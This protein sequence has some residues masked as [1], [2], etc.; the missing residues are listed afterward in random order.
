MTRPIRQRARPSPSTTAAIAFVALAAAALFPAGA[1]AAR[2]RVEER[3]PAQAALIFEAEPAEVNRVALTVEGQELDKVRYSLRDPGADLDAGPGCSGGGTPGTVV[4]CLVPRSRPPVGFGDPGRSVTLSFALADGSDSLDTANVD[5]DGGGGA[6]GVEVDGGDGADTLLTGATRD[7]IDPGPGGDSVHSAEG[8]DYVDARASPDAPDLIDLGSGWDQVSYLAAPAPVTIALNG[9]ADDG[10]AG[11]KD[12]LLATER[13]IGSLGADTLIGGDSETTDDDGFAERLLGCGGGDV[14]IGNGGNDSLRHWDLPCRVPASSVSEDAVI[15][16]GAGN[17]DIWGGG[18]ADLADGGPGED[19]FY[20]AAGDDRA[21]GG[22]GRDLVYGHGGAD[23][24]RGGRGE[25]RIDGGVGLFGTPGTSDG[26][27]DLIDCGASP[28]DHALNVERLDR[29]HDCERVHR[30]YYTPPGRASA[31]RTQRQRGKRIVVRVKVKA[32]ERLT[33]TA[34]GKIKINPTYELKPQ[35]VKLATGETK[36][37]K[38]KPKKAA[39]RI[40]QALKRGEKAT[41]KVT[42]RL[43]DAAG[44]TETEKLRVRLKR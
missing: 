4:I 36:T 11:E 39:G 12:N 1:D 44:N 28:R 21:S 15:E 32:K 34:S 22:P 5:A 19:S 6:L 13:V 24:L 18:G 41:A 7:R 2:V 38:L 9:V 37:L 23:R 27:G 30:T 33:A 43:T 40:A 26:A 3:S 25:D 29:T 42:V 14:L 16:G 17:D 31:A 10:A 8:D 35:K 20:M